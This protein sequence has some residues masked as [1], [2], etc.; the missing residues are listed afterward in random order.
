MNTGILLIIDDDRNV[1][2]TTRMFPKQ[3]FT[4]V[5]IEERPKTCLYY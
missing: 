5:Q 3:E 4:R 2:E 1:L